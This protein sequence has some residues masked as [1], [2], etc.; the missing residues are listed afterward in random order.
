MKEK[1]YIFNFIKNIFKSN[2]RDKLSKCYVYSINDDLNINV[3]EDADETRSENLYENEKEVSNLNIEAESG[4]ETI[5]MDSELKK[6]N[7]L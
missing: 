2:N 4:G 1:E 6:I 3:E 5:D 7:L